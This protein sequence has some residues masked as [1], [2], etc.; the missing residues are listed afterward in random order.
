[1]QSNRQAIRASPGTEAEDAAVMCA[2]RKITE[3]GGNAEVKRTA[4]GRLKV[5]AVEKHIAY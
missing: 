4:D 3:R 2:I 1:M 5:Y